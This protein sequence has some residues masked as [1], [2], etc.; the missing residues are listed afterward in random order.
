VEP[1]GGR[2]AVLV[3]TSGSMGWCLSGRSKVSCRDTAAVLAALLTHISDDAW[4]C[5][6]DTDASPL[7]F[8]GTSVLADIEAVPASGGG[9]DM[10][11]GF[12]CLMKSGFDADRVVVLSDNE[13]NGRAW[14]TNDYGHKTIQTYLERY[15]AQVGHDVWCHAIDL[16]GYGTQQFM[17][18]KVNIMAGWSEQVLRF[19]ALAEQGLGGLVDEIE[20]VEL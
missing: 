2:T 7:A 16:Q 8:T 11:A 18:A 10:A 12:E 4:A 20:A 5:R 13:V 3:D 6:F 15:R 1:L 14:R 17:G 9:T 19:V